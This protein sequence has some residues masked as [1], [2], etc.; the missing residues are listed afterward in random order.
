MTRAQVPLGVLDLSKRL[1]A[2]SR[3]ALA[4]MIDTAQVAEEAAYRRFWVA[5]HHVPGTSH[6]CPE[7]MAGI[8][9]ARTSRIRVGSGAVLLRYYSP[10][11]VAETFLALEALFPGRM[12]LGVAQG[13][14]VVDEAVAEALVSGNAWELE[15]PVFNRKVLE[16]SELLLMSGSADSPRIRP[17][18][19]DV[20]APPLWVLGSGQRSLDLAVRV[21]RPYAMSVF[22]SRSQTASRAL[23]D[24]YHARTGNGSGCLTL[25]VS[26]TAAQTCTEAVTTEAA[27]VANGYLAANAV[28]DYA[29]VVTKLMHLMEEARAEELLLTSFGEA[30][31]RWQA[32]LVEI[33][34]AWRAERD[35]RMTSSAALTADGMPE[36]P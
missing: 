1:G 17:Q 26:V 24:E 31:A 23:A 2:S 30:P 11:K 12:D 33:A 3:E 6:T 25:A 19:D 27:K 4:S 34:D 22:T 8:I 21:G 15:S 5:E 35:P 9:A 29:S 10:L 36:Q 20:V 32:I 18:P 7:I 13:P 14:G 28:G 16:L